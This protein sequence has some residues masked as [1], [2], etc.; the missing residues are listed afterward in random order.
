[1]IS[2]RVFNVILV[3]LFIFA[4]ISALMVYFEFVRL[5]DSLEKYG[6]YEFCMEPY[7]KINQYF[8]FSTT[9]KLINEKNFSQ[10]PS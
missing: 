1:M 6:C 2:D 3:V 5:N 9:E 4:I 7:G 8:N 10:F